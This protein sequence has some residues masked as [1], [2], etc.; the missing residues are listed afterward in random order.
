M[1]NFTTN[2]LKYYKDRVLVPL[3]Y[4]N[5]DEYIKELNEERDILNKDLNKALKDIEKRPENKKAHN[6]RDNPRQTVD[7]NERKD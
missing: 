5:F 1:T 2:S 3:A 7:A 4:I 6:K